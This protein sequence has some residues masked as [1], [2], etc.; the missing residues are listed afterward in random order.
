MS[1]GVDG[2]GNSNRDPREPD[3]IALAS[4]DNDIILDVLDLDIPYVQRPMA[5]MGK[6]ALE[7]LKNRASQL[8]GN[9]ASVQRIELNPTLVYKE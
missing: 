2:G 6:I 8:E 7:L 1:E 9:T 3:G 4:F 5:E